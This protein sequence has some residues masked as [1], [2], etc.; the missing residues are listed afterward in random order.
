MLDLAA[1]TGGWCHL[2][3][4]SKKAGENLSLVCGLGR[5]ELPDGNRVES[6]YNE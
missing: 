2:R 1:A 4:L 5:D 3:V 6:I